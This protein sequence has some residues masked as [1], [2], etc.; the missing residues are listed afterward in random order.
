V[1]TGF[2]IRLFEGIR[3][4]FVLTSLTNQNLLQSKQKKMRIGMLQLRHFSRPLCEIRH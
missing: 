3:T 1:V 4:A 2:S